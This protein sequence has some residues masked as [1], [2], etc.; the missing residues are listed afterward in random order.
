MID[1]HAEDY[2]RPFAA[3][4]TDEY[5]LCFTCHMMVH[6]R[7]RN[8]TAWTRYREI[9]AGGGRFAP[10]YRRDFGTVAKHFL[11][12]PKTFAGAMAGSPWDPRPTAARLM[13]SAVEASA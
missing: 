7:F 10:F 11:N 2:S 1:A 6:C 4:K 3:G 9:I 12:G 5:H 13:R 8:P